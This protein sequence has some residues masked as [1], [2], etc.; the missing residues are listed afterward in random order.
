MKLTPIFHYT[1]TLFAIVLLPIA[2]ATS[3]ADMANTLSSGGSFIISILE[4]ACFIIGLIFMAM[5]YMK[6]KIHKSQ[7]KL[8]P[9]PGVILIFIL[10]ILIFAI[11]FA[12]YLA[13]TS[14]TP[15]T[16]KPIYYSIDAPI[17]IQS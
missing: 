17:R 6:Y 12:D 4:I 8:E 1:L 9:L 15:D 3:L 16:K 2:S 5:A 11:P 10:G 13:P 7:P 14:K